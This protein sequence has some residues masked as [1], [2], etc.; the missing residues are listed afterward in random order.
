MFKLLIL[1]FQGLGS[2]GF[3]KK[4]RI[5]MNSLQNVI[6]SEKDFYILLKNEYDKITTKK[7]RYDN[8]D[9]YRRYRRIGRDS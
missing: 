2:L 6:I 1:V 5:V 4:G 7:R 9:I 8:D 3:F